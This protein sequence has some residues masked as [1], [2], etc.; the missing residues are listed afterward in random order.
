MIHAIQAQKEKVSKKIL[1]RNNYLLFLYYKQM[2]IFV[3]EGAYVIVKVICI[4]SSIMIDHNSI[5]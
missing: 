3:S 4:N 1:I 2:S 5:I